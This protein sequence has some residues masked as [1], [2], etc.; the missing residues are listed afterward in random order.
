MP[1]SSGR[2]ARAGYW[3]SH[4]AAVR[5]RFLPT[6]ESPV[7][8]R[9]RADTILVNSLL[10]G[11]LISSL[12]PHITRFQGAGTARILEELSCCKKAI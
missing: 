10:I 5:N 1:E 9:M 12:Q 4:F 11:I 8:N 6:T 3:Y 2:G 7:V